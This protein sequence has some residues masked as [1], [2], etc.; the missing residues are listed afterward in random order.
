[1]EM[2]SNRGDP[3]GGGA[4]RIQATSGAITAAAS[5]LTPRSVLE[6]NERWYSRPTYTSPRWV[7]EIPPTCS[8][9]P[10]GSSAPE[11]AQIVEARPVAGRENDRVDALAL[12][13]AP[14]DLVPVER[15]EHRSHVEQPVG[16]RLA[17]PDAVGDQAA[18]ADLGS[19]TRPEAS[20]T[21]SL[22]ASSARPCRRCRCGMKRSG[23]RTAIVT[24]ATRRE[25]VGDLSRGIARADHDHPHALVRQRVAVLGDVQQAA[26]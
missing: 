9:P 16:E 8:G 4:S 24:S 20:Q 17:Q 13:L 25:L 12:A 10:N 18:A 3:D 6:A 21:R 23:W 1:M 5:A 15:D 19:A 26:R 11:L 22:A 7:V 14:H 2:V